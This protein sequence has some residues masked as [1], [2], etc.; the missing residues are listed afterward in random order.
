MFLLFLYGYHFLI[1]SNQ[2]PRT[3]NKKNNFNIL[4]ELTNRARVSSNSME[5]IYCCSVYFKLSAL[6]G[7]TGDGKQF[8]RELFLHTNY[9]ALRVTCGQTTRFSPSKP[10]SI[11]EMH[12]WCKLGRSIYD[13]KCKMSQITLQFQVHCTPPKSIIFSLGLTENIGRV[14]LLTML[15]QR[16]LVRIMNFVCW[17]VNQ[18]GDFRY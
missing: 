2:H 13:S 5:E 10:S 7:S 11:D 17:Y 3:A 1:H 9:R 16:D 14:L 15:V 6:C 12:D 18:G 8:L 4:S